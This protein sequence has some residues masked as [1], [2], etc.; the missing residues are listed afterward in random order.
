MFASANLFGGIVGSN[1]SAFQAEIFPPKR[2][3]FWNA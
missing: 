2:L 3:T 1:K